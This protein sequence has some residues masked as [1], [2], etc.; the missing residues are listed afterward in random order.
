MI[1][2][3]YSS[4]VNTSRDAW[5]YNFNQ[6]IL[7]ENMKRMIDFYNDQVFRWEQ[8]EER[9][10]NVDDFVVSDDKKI[11]WSSSLKLKLQG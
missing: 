6:N 10:A 5:V 4:G 1:F 3:T 7:T 11:K 8:R 9:D 2:K